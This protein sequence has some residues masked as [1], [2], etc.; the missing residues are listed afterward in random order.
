M[1]S[2]LGSA[3]LAIGYC[4]DGS[5]CHTAMGEAYTTPNGAVLLIVPVLLAYSQ[6]SRN[7]SLT[8]LLA[9]KVAAS[10]YPKEWKQFFRFSLLKH[11]HTCAFTYETIWDCF[12]GSTQLPFL[13]HTSEIPQKLQHK[14]LLLTF[15]IWFTFELLSQL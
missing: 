3:C 4:H 7:H 8:P 5:P 13:M 2:C 15:V 11:A 10:C 1:A 14:L 9:H 12:V 6:S